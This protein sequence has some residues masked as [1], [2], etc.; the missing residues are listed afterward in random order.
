MA[1]NRFQ[2]VVTFR[3]KQLTLTIVLAVCAFLWRPS[4]TL[5]VMKPGEC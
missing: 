3:V 1:F 5:L 2:V 4:M